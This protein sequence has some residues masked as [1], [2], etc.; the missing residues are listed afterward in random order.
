MNVI[1]NA[2]DFGYSKVFNAKMLDL[3]EKGAIKSVTV[4]VDR[5]DSAQSG[6]VSELKGLHEAKG[7][8]VGIEIE[9][10]SPDAD[11]KEIRRQYDKF[12]SIFGFKPSHFNIHTPKALM[13]MADSEAILKRLAHK[14]LEF[15]HEQNLPMNNDPDYGI[16]NFHGVKTTEPLII[17][18]PLSL[19][20]L[21]ARIKRMEKGKTYEIIFHPGEYDPGCPSSLNAERK[22]DYDKVLILKDFIESSGGTIT[23]YLAMKGK[24]TRSKSW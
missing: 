24:D 15:A 19:D 20:E 5:L 9:F 12:L 3:L 8:G 23:S 18:T 11:M 17:G 21:E 4:L 10:G 14:V 16:S 22:K 13:E 2:D 6:Q 7:V 1:I